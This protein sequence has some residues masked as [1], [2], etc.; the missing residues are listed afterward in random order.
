MKFIADEKILYHSPDPQ[1]L[2]CYTPW[3]DH[4][5][6]GRLVASFDIAGPSLKKE[7]GPFSDHGDFG[8][9][10][11]RIYISDDNG[12]SWRE[13]GRLPMLHARVFAAGKALYAFGHS[14][15]ILIARS[16][17]NGETWSEPVTLDHPL[18][19]YQKDEIN[20]FGNGAGGY[21]KVNG[22]VWITWERTPDL[23]GWNGGDPI[24][25]CA[26]ENDDLSKV[27]S[28][29]FSNVLKFRDVVNTLPAPT[30]EKSL[31]WLESS[32]LFERDKTNLFYDPEFKHPLV[33]LRLSSGAFH[34]C[35]A[36]LQGNEAED[37]TLS[38]DLPEHPAGNKFMYVPFP[39]GNMKFQT[40][41]DEKSQLYWL[42]AT[43]TRVGTFMNLNSEALSPHIRWNSERRQLGLFYS[44]NAFD[45]LLAGIVAGGETES[46]SR[47]YASLATAGDDMIVMSRSGDTDAK[48]T[49]DT[50]MIT[51]HRIKD[52]RSLACA[53][54]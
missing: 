18:T 30:A 10:Q 41:W 52:F 21:E 8:S 11:M 33:F 23:D 24:V 40:I 50:D 47:H 39:G 16:D 6:N 44:R 17:D 13:T 26:D 14:A 48:S 12:Y 42:I 19:Q 36:M 49:H 9:N 7:S 20:S 35:A 51:Y 31:C 25:M 22:K 46:Q 37:G 27:E 53:N 4:A 43:T 3:I 45:W 54:D 15:R 1:G 32:L 29:R 38:L 34:N 28:W 2:Y 5:F